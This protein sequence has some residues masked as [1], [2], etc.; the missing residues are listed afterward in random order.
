M[1]QT[2][3]AQFIEAECV[4]RLSPA[5]VYRD[6]KF[7][8]RR[9]SYFHGMCPLA[10]GK[11]PPGSFVVDA[12]TL[13]WNCLQ[14]CHRGG[15]SVL[16][17]LNGGAFPIPGTGEVN[18]ALERLSQIARIPRAD[19]PPITP[20]AEQQ[21][22]AQDRVAS[23][24]ETFLIQA[25][26]RL[27]AAA[28]K[29]RQ[30]ALKLLSR[31]GLDDGRLDSLPLGLVGEISAA[32]FELEEVGYSEQEIDASSLADDARLTG[33]LIGPIRD[34]FGR[35]LSF[36]ARD[37]N[38]RSPK[39]LFKGTW[40]DATPL[41]GLDTALA[42]CGPDASGLENLIVLERLLDAVALHSL[43]FRQAAAIAG[44]ASDMTP[45]RWERL[46]DLG[47]RRVTL[48][49]DDSESS[50]NNTRIAVE[51][52]LGADSAPAVWVLSP[53]A[54]R[55]FAT[56]VAFIRA[57]GVAEFRSLVQARA[58]HGY[59]YRAL[60]ILRRHESPSGWIDP[61]RHAAWKEAIEFYATSKPE[62]FPQLDAYFVPAIETGLQRTWD[63]FQPLGGPPETTARTLQLASC[64][65]PSEKAGTASVATEHS[66][67]G[68]LFDPSPSDQVV[69]RPAISR[70]AVTAHPHQDWDEA[71]ELATSRYSARDPSTTML[72]G[73]AAKDAVHGHCGIHH[74]DTLV[75]FCFD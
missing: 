57:R 61:C 75:C 26:W 40:K 11:S 39:F 4:P 38:D 10:H 55:P 56:G 58:V 15:Q 13:R 28:A 71:V 34:R 63:T 8:N 25:H 65:E 22:V 23:L 72:R 24:L 1:S 45:E 54:L 59:N 73:R 43:G 47:V 17:Y 20:E 74:C 29:I 37:P 42:S 30:P 27:H 18:A 9:S 21:L 67:S 53:E 60:S 68:G 6:V 66:V 51:N 31:Q 5:E 16:A 69:S 46:G 52:A 70:P 32:R 12:R 36:W 50:R 33:R 3:L 64:L 41:V 49:P 14:H 35:I 48:V 2:A 7:S 62:R 44:P 19:L